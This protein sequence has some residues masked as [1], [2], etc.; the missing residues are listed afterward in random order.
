MLPFTATVAAA[1]AAPI[2]AV[3]TAIALLARRAATRRR[4]RP[5]ALFSYGFAA[6]TVG[7]PSAAVAAL[8]F[9][10]G[11]AESLV[12]GALV[13]ATGFGLLARSVFAG[14]PRADPPAG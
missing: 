8:L 1:L 11:L 14:A 5:L 4:S 7:P 6:I 10:Q 2:L 12:V 13:T 3:G 9:H